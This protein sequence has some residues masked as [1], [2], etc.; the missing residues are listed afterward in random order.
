MEQN[1]NPPDQARVRRSPQARLPRAMG[2]G[3]VGADRFDARQG[4]APIT[5]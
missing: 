2:R 4:R 3:A 1:S 5:P